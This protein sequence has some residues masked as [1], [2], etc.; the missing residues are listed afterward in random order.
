M[1][2]FSFMWQIVNHSWIVLSF[3]SCLY[4]G[5]NTQSGIP[6]N[7]QY[8]HKEY[9]AFF[10]HFDIQDTLF[11]DYN[12]LIIGDITDFIYMGKACVLF[13]RISDSL[14]YIDIENNRYKSLTVAEKLPGYHLRPIALQKVSEKKFMV[15]SDRYYYVLFSEGT[16]N[17][18]FKTP[19]YRASFKFII[20]N[21]NVV[22]YYH[23]TPAQLSLVEM[24]MNTGQIKTLIPLNEVGKNLRNLLIRNPINGGFLYDEKAGFFI[25][26]A[27]E[28]MIYRYDF[29]GKLADIYHSSYKRFKMVE[30]DAIQ[31]TPEAI[32]GFW[33][34][35]RKKPFDMVISIHLLNENTILAAYV[36]DKRPYIELF[37]KDTGK[38][39]NNEEIRLPLPPKYCSDNLLFLEGPPQKI[40][41]EDQLPNPYLI[42]FQLKRKSFP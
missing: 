29:T 5:E 23:P 39:L 14:F 32:M 7:E 27:Y 20:Q 16:I 37:D 31:N 33:R 34:Q 9:K 15:L 3:I 4:S 8:I 41:K 22:F 1:N 18:V 30:H 24:N 2:R 26:D 6:F 11:F 38:V 19:N 25:A 36:I 10:K 42:K 21:D 17:K 12:N 40:E 28:N 35:S 13:D